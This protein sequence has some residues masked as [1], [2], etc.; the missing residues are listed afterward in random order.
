MKTREKTHENPTAPVDWRRWMVGLGR[1]KRRVREFLGLSQEQLARLAGVSQGAISRLE[2]GRGLATPLLVVMRINYALKRAFDEMDPELLSDEARRLRA[3]DDRLVPPQDGGGFKTIPILKD[4]SLEEMIR[5]YW[6]LPER[7][8]RTLAT[9][10][11]AIA[12]ALGGEGAGAAPVASGG[13]GHRDA[14]E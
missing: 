11:R 13:D 5:L 7:G 9:V 10:V 3:I 2:G 12:A 8:R 14:P 4:P 6:A 1:S